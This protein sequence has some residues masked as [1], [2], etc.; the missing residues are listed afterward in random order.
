MP[1]RFPESIK[2]EAMEL[3]VAGDKTAKEIAEIISKDGAEVKPVTIYAWAKQYSWGEQKNTARS[4]NQQK[5]AENEGQRF[6]RLQREQLENYTSLTS[7]AYQE[8]DGLSFDRAFDAAKAMDIGIKG[9]REVEKGMVSLQF[10]Q[11][12]MSILIEEITDQDT[13]ARIAVKLKT[14]HQSQKET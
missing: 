5:I 1:K 13:L 10:I 7:K 4:D 12:I 6:A 8:L 9:Q 11:D 2:N 14:L 3:F